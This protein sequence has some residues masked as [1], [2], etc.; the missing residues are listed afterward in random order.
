MVRRPARSTLFP[1]T[2]LFRSQFNVKSGILTK[3]VY[4]SL[5]RKSA[6]DRELLVVGW[7]T[8]FLVGAA[9]TVLAVIMAASGQSIFQVMLTFNTLISLAYGPPALL[10]LAV[11]RR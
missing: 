7:V 1:Y 9:T 6:G 5:L 8:T 2:T 4:Q 3:D 10:G 11:R